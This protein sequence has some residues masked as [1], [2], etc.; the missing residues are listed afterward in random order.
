MEQRKS[1]K[2]VPSKEPYEPTA[3]EVEAL[4][5]QITRREQRLPVPR[6][7]V[8]TKKAVP[9][10]G[11]DHPDVAL[12]QL[13]LMEALGTT[14]SAFLD[15]YL[16][17]LVNVGTRGRD[18]DERDLNFMLAAVAGIEPRDHIEAM[19]AAQM[20]AVHNATMT[21]AR[22][23]TVVETLPQQDSAERAFNRLA[24]TFVAQMEALN[25]H[26]GKGQQKMT[27]EHVHVH[28]GGQAIVG[29]V[30]TGG[31][32]SAKTK[33]RSHGPAASAG[34]KAVEHAPRAEMPR[35]DQE[36]HA[37]PEPGTKR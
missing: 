30:E 4:K 13:L 1:T 17:Q 33:E 27:V 29:N 20:A 7:E 10:I 36:R 3:K 21:F 34:R 9:E 18:V 2:S 23:L 24:R 8:G 22:R 15:G 35:E 25:R 19:L 11:V 31:T 14:S 6:L 16:S 37:V 32:G 12:G 28:E 5:A 26:R